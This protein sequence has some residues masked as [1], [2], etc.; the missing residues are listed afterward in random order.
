MLQTGW[1]FTTSTDL[2]GDLWGKS[3]HKTIKH[4]R[5]NKWFTD[6]LV[7][8]NIP[9][10]T[11]DLEVRDGQELLWTSRLGSFKSFLEMQV[12]GRWDIFF[13]Q[14]P[15]KLCPLQ[16]CLCFKTRWFVPTVLL[17]KHWMQ[18]EDMKYQKGIARTNSSCRK[19]LGH[20]IGELM[21]WTAWKPSAD[22]WFDPEKFSF[23][24]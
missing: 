1:K 10:R 17:S 19:E 5:V 2:I 20:W 18:M 14:T 23:R 6:N 3:F 24:T 11:Q 7:T 21:M 12:L 13:M 16:T 4:V 8:K 15:L 22:P 9:C